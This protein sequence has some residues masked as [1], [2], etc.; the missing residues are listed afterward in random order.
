MDLLFF[1][2]IYLRIRILFVEVFGMMKQSL[3]LLVGQVHRRNFI[4]NKF[5]KRKFINTIHFFIRSLENA[6]F[7]NKICSQ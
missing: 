2:V 6:I 4:S 7:I 3:R 5:V 1:Q